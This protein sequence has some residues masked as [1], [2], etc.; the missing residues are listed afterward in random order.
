MRD[1]LNTDLYMLNKIDPKSFITVCLM[2][3]YWQHTYD[4]FSLIICIGTKLSLCIEQG[5]SV[6]MLVYIQRTDFMTDWLIDWLIDWFI[7]W[8]IDWLIDLLIDL[9]IDRLID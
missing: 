7:D 9:F 1:A 2:C 5:K 3:G 8:L 6:P 4:I